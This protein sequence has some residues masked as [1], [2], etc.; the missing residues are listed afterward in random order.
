MDGF[1]A[2]EPRGPEAPKLPEQD[3]GTRPP[4]RGEITA[5]TVGASILAFL[6]AGLFASMAG[7][8][9]AGLPTAASPQALVKIM[10]KQGAFQDC[11]W[12]SHSGAQ[13]RECHQ[14]PQ[15]A[16]LQRLLSNQEVEYNGGLGEARLQSIDEARDYLSLANG[17]SGSF[18][19]AV[20][21]TARRFSDRQRDVG[22]F[23][24][25]GMTNEFK[26]LTELR[27][28]NGT[29]Q[30]F[31]TPHRTVSIDSLDDLKKA[32][33]LYGA[34]A[35]QLKL[36]PENRQALL[37]LEA[38]R[39]GWAVRTDPITIWQSLEA[40]E[41]IELEIFL[42]RSTSVVTVN[43]WEKLREAS[44]RAANQMECER[45][46]RPSNELNASYDQLIES[47]QKSVTE[48]LTLAS[49]LQSDALKRP[50][51]QKAVQLSSLQKLRS[52][53]EQFSNRAQAGRA[54]FQEAQRNQ[55][56]ESSLPLALVSLG[57][58]DLPKGPGQP[59]EQ[60]RRQIAEA[61]VQVWRLYWELGKPP[62]PAGW[63]PGDL[64]VG[65]QP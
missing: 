26:L 55:I 43:S 37:Q 30:S 40:G 16:V 11:R 54:H 5:R 7:A 6:G 22:R 2:D 21:E 52:S 31:Q 56:V 45:Y 57:D 58:P 10:E 53:L 3:K 63:Q 39:G 46:Q 44:R 20:V 38:L 61:E 48:A 18:G 34:N 24:Y 60:I 27:N 59:F 64:L 41:P 12:V 29:G 33:F 36:E 15:A 42:E 32:D 23:T 4:D 19:Q 51:R 14:L 47:L 49:S 13:Q 65:W 8:S 50:D 35:S 9:Q 62:A 28:G 17:G 1:Q 25:P